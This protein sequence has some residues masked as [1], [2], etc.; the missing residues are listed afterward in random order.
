MFIFTARLTR[1][2]L[3]IAVLAGALILCLLILLAA[4]GGSESRSALSPVGS[5]QE[6]SGRIAYISNLGWEVE[7]EPIETEEV[8]IPEEFGEV[9]E[10]YNSLQQ[11]AGFDLS[12]YKGKRVKRYCYEVLNYPTGEQGVRLNLLIY[13]NKVI[14]GDIGTVAID[15]FMTG[16]LPRQG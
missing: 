5:L 11:Q 4:R 2:K 9:Y 13:N 8:I 14:G 7:E 3:V 15:G 6:N 16:L 12:D 1:K 10:Q